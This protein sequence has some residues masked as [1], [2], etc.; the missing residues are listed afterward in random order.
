MLFS[1]YVGFDM[2]IEFFKTTGL[3][4][5][6]VKEVF[7]VIGILYFVIILRRSV[8]RWMGMKMVNAITKYKWNESV[9]SERKKRVNTYLLLEALVMAFVG[10]VFI[11]ICPLAWLVSVAL[12]IGTIDSLFFIVIGLSRNTYR[13]GVT[14]QAIVV[15][16]REVKVLYFS[17]LREVSMHSES[18]Y[19][20]YKDDLQLTFPKNCIDDKN[21]KSFKD[22]I[23]SSVNR[24]RVFFSE[25]VR[26]L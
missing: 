19:F 15:A 2:P 22:V 6:Y 1:I 4:L 3:H 13:V 8:R 25:N 10:F 12:F 21:K 11:R 20:D 16:D 26:A 18:F 5:P 9:S 14:S 23:E 7:L 24:D 17:G